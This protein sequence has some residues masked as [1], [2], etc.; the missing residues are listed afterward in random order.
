MWYIN[1]VSNFGSGQI[2]P[3]LILERRFMAG[4]VE[5]LCEENIVP[6]IEKMGYDVI[7]VEYAKRID[8]MNLTFVIDKSGGI[9]LDDCEKVH[10]VV[11][12]EL[13]KLNPTGDASYILNVSSAGLDR[14]IKNYKDFIRNKGKLVEV[15]LFSPLEGKKTYEGELV[16][17]TEAEVIISIN[18]ENKVFKR[19]LVAQVVPVIKF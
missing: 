19:D 16:N 5:T 15:K 18:G 13:D 11:D 6:I 14:P 2:C 12:E 8:G 3:L 4:K 7:E 1:Y 9:T 17:F 10:K